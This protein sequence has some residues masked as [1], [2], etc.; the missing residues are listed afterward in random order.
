[1]CPMTNSRSLEN[2]IFRGLTFT[3]G[4]FSAVDIFD[5]N[6]Y[7]GDARTQFM[8]WG[9][10]TNEAW[11]YPAD[12]IGYDTGLAVELNQPKWTLRYGF[13]QVPQHAE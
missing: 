2:R 3:L 7:A 5:T 8:N 10:V 4:R 1:M 11:D 9:L 12:V 6:A 13:F